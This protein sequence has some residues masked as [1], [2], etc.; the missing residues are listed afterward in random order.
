[1]F[2]KIFLFLHLSLVIILIFIILIQKNKKDEIGTVFGKNTTF[3]DYKNISFIQKITF[4]IFLLF[5]ISNISLIKF[6]INTKTYE[7][8]G[9]K[10]YTFVLTKKINYKK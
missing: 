10:Q 2:E 4:L 1:M 8:I 7:F 6:S 5:I 3:D 9:L